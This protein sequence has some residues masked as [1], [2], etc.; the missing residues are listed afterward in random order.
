M[1]DFDYQEAFSRNLGWL[2]ELD[3]AKVANYRI[4]LPG[5]GGVGGH[6]LHSLLRLGFQKFH[7]ADMDTFDLANFNRQMGAQVST[8]GKEKTQVL[9]DM[10]KDIN[11]NAEIKIFSQG[12]HEGNMPSFL[13]GVDL[14]IDCLDV[15]VLETRRKLYGLAEKMKIPVI[16]AA[17]LG[18]G[19][20]VMVF[21]P[22]KM[23]FN[24]YFAF[25]DQNLKEEE[26]VLYFL[27]GMSPWIMHASYL[28][29]PEKIVLRQRKVSS[30]NIGCSSA[31]SAAAA[32]ALKLCIQRGKIL[33]APW[34][35]QVDFF[36]NKLKKF[37]R[38]FGNR[39]L[40]QKLLIRYMNR[41][42]AK[43]PVVVAQHASQSSKKHSGSEAARS[44]LG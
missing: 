1:Q 22:E 33:Y 42:F 19:T 18:M 28:A 36:H 10:A 12:V 17:P 25:D 41:R 16:S 35:Y 9:Y 44:Y 38:P 29:A 8:I 3:Q 13:N 7:I 37:W 39:N 5:L 32:I 27:A 23:P 15:F 40:L 11:P 2:S 21:S 20:S 4:A 24:R 26:M 30:L 43:E 31:A 6:H 34:G 14:V